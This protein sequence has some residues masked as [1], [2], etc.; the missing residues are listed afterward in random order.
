M[1]PP[2]P[3]A[4]PLKYAPSQLTQILCADEGGMDVRVRRRFTM[5]RRRRR[6]RQEG[7]ARLCDRAIG[8]EGPIIVKPKGPMVVR[9]EGRTDGPPEDSPASSG[10]IVEPEGP[11]ARRRATACLH[12]PPDG[13]LRRF[14]CTVLK[15]P[16]NKRAQ[17]IEHRIWP[18]PES[19]QQHPIYLPTNGHNHQACAK[20]V[21]G[22]HFR[23]TNRLPTNWYLHQRR[24]RRHGMRR[25]LI[26]G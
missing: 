24:W 1:R 4:G 18:V 5:R 13:G 10:L 7:P 19:H 8:P 22:S 21:P 6:R 12:G 15:R 9:P 14:L 23:S 20:P 17:Q 25:G 3:A 2:R 11:M 16:P 26:C